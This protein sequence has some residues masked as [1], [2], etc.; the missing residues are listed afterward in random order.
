MTF[1]TTIQPS[2][3]TFPIE[4]HE[5]ILEAALKHGYVLPYSCRDGVCGVCK[6]KVTSGLVDHGK[7][8]DTAL[9]EAEKAQ[10]MALFCCAKPQSDLSIECKEVSAVK[11]IQVKTLPCRVH[12]MTRLADDVM[13][14]KLKLPTN[15]RLQFLAGQYIDILQKDQKPRSFSLANAPHNDELL[16]LHVRN[17]AG[18]AFTHHVFSEMKERDILRFKGPLGTFFLRED[19]DKPIIFVASG[20]GFAP[21]KAIIEHALYI[22]VKRPMH[23]YWGARKLSDL[24]L[25][26]MAKQWE[27]QGIRFTPVLSDALPEDNWQGRTGFVHRAVMEDYA[28]L[29]AHE[30]YAC[31][32]PVVVEAAHT[33]FTGQCGLPN[34]AFYSDAF[35]FTP[36]TPAA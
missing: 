17:I 36:K 32:A 24:Y 23:F 13:V 34:D 31:G 15:E 28:D 5:T 6:G 9:S 25:L 19:S 1:N 7:P 21:I 30:V 16:E 26:D 11:D 3:H 18:G 29:S 35:T 14:L 22:G 4:A 10:G 33:D 27:S 2:G 8:L 20:T 12:S